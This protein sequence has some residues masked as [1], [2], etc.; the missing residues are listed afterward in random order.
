MYDVEKD[1]V[2]LENFE[3]EMLEYDEHLTMTLDVYL[4]Y[5]RY[6]IC[7]RDNLTR[8][9]LYFNILCLKSSLIVLKSKNASLLR[10]LIACHTFYLLYISEIHINIYFYLQKIAYLDN[11]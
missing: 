2:F 3:R 10:N 4:E 7:K 9:I 1:K 11:M 8:K 6:P 5:L